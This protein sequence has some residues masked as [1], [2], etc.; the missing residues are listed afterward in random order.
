[1]L[2]FFVFVSQYS[3]LPAPS[4]GSCP[5]SLFL[6]ALTDLPEP[7]ENKVTLSPAFA[8]LAS[9]VKANPFACHSYKK[10]PGWESAIVNFFVAQPILA[11]LFHES[12][13][14]SHGQRR[15]HH[16]SRNTRGGSPPLTQTNPAAP[17]RCGP[18]TVGIGT[19][20]PAAIPPASR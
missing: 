16:G 9:H 15:T 7:N 1:M 18:T 4:F 12:R 5:V 6:A 19:I 10:H 17:A 11:V 2:S 13:V 8:T 3:L 14:T 20:P